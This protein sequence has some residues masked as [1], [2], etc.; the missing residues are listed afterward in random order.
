MAKMNIKISHLTQIWTVSPSPLY[1]ASSLGKKKIC[2]WL[3]LTVFS[4]KSGETPFYNL[5]PLQSHSFIFSMKSFPLVFH[6]G[7]YLPFSLSPIWFQEWSR[8]PSQFHTYSSVLLH[9]LFFF[10]G[11]HFIR[12]CYY[13]I[14]GVLDTTWR[15][16]H[17]FSLCLVPELRANHWW[18]A[19]IHLTNILQLKTKQSCAR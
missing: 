7:C 12:H 8:T 10:N 17:L 18:W 13:I 6:L 11:L 4:P 15:L 2:W 19:A 5:S 1:L 9:W 14:W 16:P 3:L